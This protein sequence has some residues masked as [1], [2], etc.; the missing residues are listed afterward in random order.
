MLDVFNDFF[1]NIEK[2]GN[3]SG[4]ISIVNEIV[5]RPKFQ[6]RITQNMTKFI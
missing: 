3:F 5:N 4:I 2:I 1:D 6:Q